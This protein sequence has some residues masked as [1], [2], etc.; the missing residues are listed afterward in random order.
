MVP[1]SSHSTRFSPPRTKEP[2]TFAGGNLS[3]IARALQP[4]AS[5]RHPPPIRAYVRSSMAILP[6]DA[7]P[8]TALSPCAPVQLDTNPAD[9]CPSTHGFHIHPSR[10]TRVD[11]LRT[12]AP[13]RL[14]RSQD[15]CTPRT[16][17]TAHARATAPPPTCRRGRALHLARAC[18]CSPNEHLPRDQ[19]DGGGPVLGYELDALCNTYRAPPLS[20][21]FY[22]YKYVLITDTDS[23]RYMHGKY[24]NTMCSLS[25]SFVTLLRLRN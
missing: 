25:C 8:P 6:A 15:R 21:T 14:G 2:A 20:H 7:P 17:T 10:Q 24:G 9:D 19:P 12:H 18:D 3:P 22:M 13:A 23:F 5:L 16:Q 1:T 11:P 4:R